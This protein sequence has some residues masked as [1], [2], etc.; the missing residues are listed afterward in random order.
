MEHEERLKAALAG[1]YQIEREI[2]SGGMATVF[3]AQDLKHNR[4]VAVKVLDPDLAQSLG[5]DRFLREI[6]T[7]AN[8]TH[9][10]ILPLFDSGEA[11]GFLF[12]VMPFVKGESL[13]TRLIKERQL[14]VEDAVQITREIADAL[15]Y[16]HE[17]GVIHRDVKPA[18]IMLEAGH[19]VLADFGVAHAVAEAKDE[20][21]TRTGTSL[22]TPAYMSPEQATGERELDGR[23]DQYALG[24]VLY[25]MLAG[26]PPFA[27]AQVEALVRQHLTEEPP[28]VT[29]ARPSV[30][31][32]VAKVIERAL[33]KSPA[34]RFKTTEEMAAALA[35]TTVPV[36]GGSR[37]GIKAFRIA[38]GVA[39]LVVLGLVGA[40]ILKSREE[41]TADAVAT[42]EDQRPSIA[43]LPFDN[44]SPDPENA[45]FADGIQEE[46][47][48]KLSSLSALRVISRS[49][50]M[51]YREDRPSSPQ[52]AQELGVGFLVEGSARIAG[53]QV[54]LTV[55]LINA[56]SDEHLWAED[57][58]LT[59][60]AA[61]LFEVEGNVARQ[62]AFQIG[63]NL[64]P[65]ERD[66]VGEVLTENTEA[67][68]LFMQ[69]TEAFTEERVW[70]RL[71]SQY[72]S[73][74]LLEQAV[75]TDP[76]FALARARLGLSLSYS[77]S[78]EEKDRGRREAEA[79]LR[80]M[81]GVPEAR[82]AIGL[83][84]LSSGQTDEALR[85]FRA[86]ERESPN[87]ALAPTLISEVQMD[88]GDFD[89][90]FRAL[91]A[92]ER[93]DPRNPIIQRALVRSF[94]FRHRYEE[95]L[96]AN[97]IREEVLPTYAGV[98]E[99]LWIY[100]LKGDSANAR[101]AVAELLEL[102]AWGF[103]NFGLYNPYDVVRRVLTREEGRVA[104]E[105]L[106]EWTVQ[107][108]GP[109]HEAPYVC[110]RRALHEEELGSK[111]L[112]RTYWDSLRVVVDSLPGTVDLEYPLIIYTGLGEKEAAIQAAEEYAQRMVGAEYYRGPAARILLAR[113]LA[114]F[115]EPDRAI[116]LLEELLPAPSWLSV[117]VL[118]VDPVWDPLRDHPRFRA[119]LEEYADDVER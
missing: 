100:L 43:V 17:E 109:C 42:P 3:L 34:D 96:E 25:E 117:P 30:P 77:T 91:K 16:A 13:R 41:P 21:I 86:A 103:Y 97:E 47:T 116:G 87:M 45:F 11:D 35:L 32:E 66:E 57:Y 104:L 33:A 39:G 5:A 18:N 4:R 119:L 38:V 6:E 46:V 50:V 26:H 79:A 44:L 74:Q 92:A 80:L 61:D 65:E 23:A 68:L 112:A 90:G 89:G 60:S 53:E 71:S 22:G 55:Q 58:D 75:E 27:G 106:L 82:L 78:G 99:R 9:P 98:R 115:D 7:A 88:R 64:T 118:Q 8:L 63:V 95:A 56:L 84:Y 59:L 73:T 93:I 14:P 48:S 19:A 49:S 52:I 67:Y 111:E 107:P 105:S 72:R 10:H 76:G 15:A 37:Q 1:R 51:Q 36:G 12:Y 113:V 40:S 70:G 24:C 20:R 31:G 28:S 83:Y 85:Q 110:I 101:A 69:G 114:H 94:I 108:T 62:I 102:D 29:G 81:P 2:G 54:R